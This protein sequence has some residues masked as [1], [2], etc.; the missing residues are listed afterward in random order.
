MRSTW[1]L[2]GVIVSLTIAVH[3]EENPNTTVIQNGSNTASVTQ[4][5]NPG[6]VQIKVERSPGHTSIYRKNGG[7]SSAIIQNSNPNAA[8]PS[9]PNAA[10]GPDQSQT[11]APKKMDSADVVAKIRE[12]AFPQTQK[13]LDHLLKTMGLPGGK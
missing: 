3:A 11:G 13:T 2:G 9:D 5:G 6:D 8:S 4:S 7:N 10:T 12:R 1:L